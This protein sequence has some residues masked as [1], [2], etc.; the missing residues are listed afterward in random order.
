[1]KKIFKIVMLYSVRKDRKLIWIR[2]MLS[3]IFLDMLIFVLL[4]VVYYDEKW[5]LYRIFDLW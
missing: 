4:S 3:E 1:M 2:C 5:K